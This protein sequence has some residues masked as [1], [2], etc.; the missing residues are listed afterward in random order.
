MVQKADFLILNGNVFTSD[1]QQ[2]FARAVA[3]VGN[4]VAWVGSDEGAAVWRG[5]GTQVVDAGGRTVMPGFIDSHF[6]LLMGSVEA[7]DMQLDGAF[8]LDEVA[9]TLR[10]WAATHDDL[11]I[12]GYQLRYTAI[13]ADRPLDRHFMDAIVADRPVLL[14]AYDTHTA[15]ANTRALQIGGLLHGGDAPAGSAIV[16]AA[17][18]TATGEL[19]EP[20]A[21]KPISDQIPKPDL[22]RKRVLLQKGLAQAARCG[23]TSV[24]NMDGDQEQIDLYAALE[25]AGE[26]TLRV[27]VPYSVK[28]ETPLGELQNAVVWRER[29]QGS[30][31]R[32]GAIKLF[33]DGVLESYTGL[34]VDEYADKPGDFGDALFSAEHFNQIAVAADQ[35][36]LQIFVH[37]CGDGA[38]RRTLDGYAVA[39]AVNGVRDSRHRV[40]HVEAI[41][42]DD[43]TRFAQL[44]VIGAM[45]PFHAPLRIE[46]NDVWTVRAGAARW[47]Y[48]FAW[49]T[50]R[51]AG[52]HHAFGSDWPVVS[53]N[54]LLGVHAARNR[55]PWKAGDPI[56]QQTL[57]DTLVAYTTGGAYAEF[58]EQHKGM[59]RAG[60][61]A[62]VVVLDTDLF[63]TPDEALKAVK[64]LLTM[65]DGKVVWREGV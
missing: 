7:A 24:H 32:A 59:L 26:M 47:P 33:M 1:V 53:M 50:L 45:Q 28:P 8:T 17:D 21:F 29:Y 57:A 46:D 3:V 55:Q 15:W 4:R 11:W 64:P 58:Q 14:F 61:V 39:Q 25:A 19:R 43:I 49:Q 56:Q 52:M 30:H 60:M 65:C 40:E 5:A 2:P 35:L 6:H 62:D 9:Q 34:M 18:G 41:H 13:A 38:V 10:Q 42:P 23:I 48:S 20:G 37:C 22:A 27:Y 63:A 16:M 12:V 44:G 36:G 54:P 31:V 51:A